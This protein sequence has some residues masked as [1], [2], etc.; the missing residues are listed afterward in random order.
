MTVSFWN[1]RYD[2]NHW[3]VFFVDGTGDRSIISPL[4]IQ[5]Y[6]FSSW[7]FGL[8]DKY[9]GLTFSDENFSSIVLNSVG[10]NISYS[11]IFG[12]APYFYYISPE[13]VNIAYLSRKNLTGLPSF[14]VS[15]LALSTVDPYLN[16]PPCRGLMSSQ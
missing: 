13:S 11:W 8:F 10:N 15:N 6:D 5:L 3:G 1:T 14:I 7:E 4:G 2:G 9:P 12:T 16:G